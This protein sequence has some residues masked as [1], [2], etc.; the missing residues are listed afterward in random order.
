MLGQGLDSWTKNIKDHIVRH[1]N[2]CGRES[3]FSCVMQKLW[4]YNSLSVIYFSVPR[5]K[6]KL[7]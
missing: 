1:G 5:P 4:A 2:K 3:C 6:Q 7:K